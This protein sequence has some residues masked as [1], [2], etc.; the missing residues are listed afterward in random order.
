M[1]EDV[2]RVRSNIVTDENGDMHLIVLG[3]I[4]D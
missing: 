2:Y 1:L 3:P 4:N